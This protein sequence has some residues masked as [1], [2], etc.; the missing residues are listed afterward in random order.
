VKHAC[1][2]IMERLAAVDAGR[3]LRRLQT[4]LLRTYVLFLG[5]GMAVVGLVFLTVR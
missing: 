4:G 1:E 2:Q 3:G 5:T